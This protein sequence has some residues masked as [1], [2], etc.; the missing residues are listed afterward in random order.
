MKKEEVKI[1][2]KKTVEEF[3]EKYADT[4]E[5]E[6]NITIVKECEEDWNE[7]WAIF[8]AFDREDSG[9]DEYLDMT[10]YDVAEMV[11]KEFK[12]DKI[13]EVKVWEETHEI[14]V[15]SNR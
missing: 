2:I 8:F 4:L 3:F 12:A 9:F 15:W 11:E 7:N 5:R 1:D 14:E 10:I 13:V 6:H